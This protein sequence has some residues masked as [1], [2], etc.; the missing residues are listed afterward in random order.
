LQRGMTIATPVS[1]FMPNNAGRHI[2]PA[3]LAV[4]PPAFGRIANATRIPQWSLRPHS[5]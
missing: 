3:A 5:R 2:A 1:R 4:L